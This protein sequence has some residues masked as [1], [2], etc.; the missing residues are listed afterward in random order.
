MELSLSLDLNECKCWEHLPSKSLV[1]MPVWC[2]V[3]PSD[4]VRLT[5]YSLTLER[6]QDPPRGKVV[7]F[8]QFQVEIGAC[9]GVFLCLLMRTMLDTMLSKQEQLTFILSRLKSL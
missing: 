9:V 1:G 7:G 2:L 6:Q 5:L 4:G 8:R 3:M